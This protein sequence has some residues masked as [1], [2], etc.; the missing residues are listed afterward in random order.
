MLTGPMADLFWR[1]PLG[2]TYRIGRVWGILSRPEAHSTTHQPRQPA[3]WSTD[4]SAATGD[5]GRAR[6]GCVARS[7]RR[8]TAIEMGRERSYALEKEEQKARSGLQAGRGQGNSRS[9]PRDLHFRPPDVEAAPAG[10][11]EN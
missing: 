4:H 10:E 5:L 1:S 9:H 2:A 11:H 3:L 8:S 6:E 7:A